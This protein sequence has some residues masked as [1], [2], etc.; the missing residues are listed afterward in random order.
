MESN[1]SKYLHQFQVFQNLFSWYKFTNHELCGLQLTPFYSL[2]WSF[3]HLIDKLFDPSN[4]RKCWEML[5]PKAHAAVL[6]WLL[7]LL[8]LKKPENIHVYIHILNLEKLGTFAHLIMKS[9]YMIL[10]LF[11]IK[12]MFWLVI[13]VANHCELARLQQR[14]LHTESMMEK[15]V[16]RKSR[17]SGK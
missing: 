6:K 16:S 5:F 12:T 4:V 10:L 17:S 14:L 3:S 1:I 13:R 8:S 9:E 7:C 2:I 15:I 11:D